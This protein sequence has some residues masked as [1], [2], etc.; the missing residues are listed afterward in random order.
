MRMEHQDLHVVFVGAGVIGGSVA[1][2]LAPHV[3]DLWVL[4]H[5]K[6]TAAMKDRGITL[7]RADQPA[8]RENV[9][10]RVIDDLGEVPRVDVCVLAVKNYDLEAAALTLK[11]SLGDS[12]IIVSM[13][14]G[15]SNQRILPRHFSRVIYCVVNYNGWMEAPGVIG[16]QK[17]GPLVVGTLDGALPSELRRIAALFDRGV[18]TEISP[19]IQS[20]THCKIVI[21]LI[22]SITT[23]IGYPDSPISDLPLFQKVVG[24]LMAEGVGI[25]RTAGFRESR[26]GGMPSWKILE[27]AS[28][29]PPWLSRPLFQHNLKKL[30]ISSMAQDV[31]QRQGTRTELES[32][33]GRVVELADQHGLA[34]P[35]NR[36]VY[37]LCQREFGKPAFVPL[38]LRD[39]WGEIASRMSS[40]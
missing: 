6:T 33:N 31:L 18:K 4:G 20:A 29:I 15:I 19:D 2:W 39:V 32:I 17:K 8:R 38:D 26:L 28:R 13:A 35:Y 5:G 30:V 37:A 27:L 11:Q 34:A 21:N 40:C 36:A 16:Y 25:L 14:N 3:P 24:G 1:G 7:F 9:R 10:V 22:N 23:L 12:P